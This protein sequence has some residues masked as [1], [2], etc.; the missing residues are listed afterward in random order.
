MPLVSPGRMFSRFLTS[1]HRSTIEAT[2]PTSGM[3]TRARR[4][5][6][7]WQ[8][9]YNDAPS[10]PRP[11]PNPPQVSALSAALLPVPSVRG[12]VKRPT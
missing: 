8:P 9:K 7:S 6:Q 3:V 4:E 11:T 10:G 2:P 5:P 12:S 1:V